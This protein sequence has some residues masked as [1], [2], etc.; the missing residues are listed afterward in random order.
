MGSSESNKSAIVKSQQKG[1]QVPSAE[2][3]EIRSRILKEIDHRRDEFVQLC[4]KVVRHPTEN[5]PGNTTALADFVGEWLR[6]QGLEIE[7]IEPKPTLKSLLS[8]FNKDMSA[9]LHF[10]FNGHFDV[11]PA[12]DPNL[13]KIP[14]FE[15][16]VAGGKIYGRGVSDMKGGLTA[17]IMT[18][19]LLYRYRGLLPA[20]VSLMAVA[21]EETGGLWG[22][23]W[24]LENQP[25]WLPDA[26][27]IGEPCSPDAVRIGEKGISWL[28]ISIAG[29]SYHGSLGLGDNCIL[30]MAQALIL[31]KD[32]TE[33]RPNIPEVL[34]PIIEKAKTHVLNEDTRGR[35]GLL[36]RPS[37]NIGRI[38][39]GI[40]VNIAPPNVTAEVD[41][42]VPFGLAPRDILDWARSRLENAGLKN[43]E[44]ELPPYHSAANYTDPEHLLTQVVI[45]NAVEHYGKQPTITIA[46]GAT[47]GRFFR[48]RGVPTIIYGPRPQG[49]GGLDEY[50]T[51]DDFIAVLKVHACAAFDYITG[52]PETRR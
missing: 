28:R 51:V 20:R 39:G 17:S 21:D 43:A 23:N 48:Q 42:R 52:A 26:C 19:A 4:A 27:I 45:K 25:G 8:T 6:N 16:R 40:K 9:K 37:F 46:T 30:Q 31:L 35:E 36:E 11:F 33:L 7:T 47:D 14:P 34:R 41:I 32:V 2:L 3:A 13:W 12:G 15:G 18:Y 5:P 10:M 22:T 50:I 38:E 1:Q 29:R 49:M 44:L 24:I